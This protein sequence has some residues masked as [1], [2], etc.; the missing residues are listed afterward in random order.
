MGKNLLIGVGGKALKVKTLYLGVGG[1]ARKVKRVYLGVG[2]K[3]RL[4]YLPF[5]F[6]SCTWV[7]YDMSGFGHSYVRFHVK[8]ETDDPTQYQRIS[9]Q[10]AT[11][12]GYKPGVM[13]EFKKEP[14]GF[15]FK[16]RTNAWWLGECVRHIVQIY[17]Y[18]PS[19]AVFASMYVYVF[20]VNQGPD[21]T[22]H[23]VE[24]VENATAW[25]PDSENDY[26]TPR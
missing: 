20:M 7:T 12:G 2:G 21:H 18:E 1:K 10:V 22:W 3:A 23:R 9:A 25:P 8:F 4:V 17:A 14:D 11:N 6:T 5:R 15:S 26:N 16:I 19:G 13:E 24:V